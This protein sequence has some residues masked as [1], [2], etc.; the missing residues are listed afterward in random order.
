MPLNM[1][2]DLHEMLMMN[3]QPHHEGLEMGQRDFNSLC[4][5]ADV[6][7]SKFIFCE[8]KQKKKFSQKNISTLSLAPS[9]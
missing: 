6:R 3:N 4:V 2:D 5:L 1:H 8:P 9:N 7:V